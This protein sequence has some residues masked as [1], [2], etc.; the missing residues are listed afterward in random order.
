MFQHDFIL[1]NRPSYF[2]HSTVFEAGLSGFHLL[3]ITEFKTSFQKR[4]AKIIKYGDYK[5]FNNNKFRSEILKCNSNYT[6]LRTF[7]ETVFNI[8][9]KYAP[10]KKSSCQ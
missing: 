4:E 5:N 10:I 3:F 2:Q 6:D 1:M 7:K 9:N 8:I